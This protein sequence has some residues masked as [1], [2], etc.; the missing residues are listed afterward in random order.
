MIGAPDTLAAQAV[1]FVV[2]NWNKIPIKQI[3][4]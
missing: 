3:A 2:A 4:Q 1:Q